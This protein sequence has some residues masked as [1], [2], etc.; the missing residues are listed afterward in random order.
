MTIFALNRSHIITMLGDSA[1]SGIAAFL[2]R[3]EGDHLPDVPIISIIDDDESV[4]TS[5]RSLV[6]SLGLDVCTFASAEE[7]LNSSH[8]DDT[9]CLITDLQMPG[10]SGIELQ[11]L[12]LARGRQ[13]PIIFVTAFPEDRIEARAMGWGALGFLSKPFETQ[14]LIEL[15]DKA[16]ETGRST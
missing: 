3:T 5:L 15:I 13:I 2:P 8:Q 11:R 7:F 9:S 12:L 10:L 1:H 14:T 4:R 6:R 16:L